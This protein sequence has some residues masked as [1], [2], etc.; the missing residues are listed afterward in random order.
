MR[1]E[2]KTDLPKVP[3]WPLPLTGEC[4]SSWIERTACFYGCEMDS[5]VSQF[6]GSSHRAETQTLDWDISCEGR[7]FLGACCSLP[8]SDLPQLSDPALVLPIQARLAFCKQ[9][10][11]EDACA[12]GQ[13]Y[14]R[15]IWLNWA[16]VHCANHRTF[17][18]SLNRSAF[19]KGPR[20]TWQE[21]WSRDAAWCQAL[22]LKPRGAGL[23]ALWSGQPA[24]VTEPL[25]GLL[26]R[27]ADPSDAPAMD[28]LT[29]VMGRWGLLESSNVPVS[30]THRIE[31]LTDAATVLASAS[32][33]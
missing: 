10:W 26:V 25:R 28:A 2:S 15:G 12:G 24:E 8:A 21:I 19:A 31:L 22:S 4:L 7:D 13:P 27:L 32:S 18:S 6:R 20:V 1:S 11:D 29:D 23:G 16:T 17:L 14:V 9:C 5:W 33:Q 30:L 3:I